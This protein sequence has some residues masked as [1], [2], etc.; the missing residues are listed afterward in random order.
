MLVLVPKTG[1]KGWNCLHHPNSSSRSCVLDFVIPELWSEE[2]NGIHKEK[3]EREGAEG[4][5]GGREAR[6]TFLKQLTR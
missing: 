2:N 5:R 4:W 6:K 1:G 3:K